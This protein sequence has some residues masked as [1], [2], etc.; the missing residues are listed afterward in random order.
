MLKVRTKNLDPSERVEAT[1]SGLGL[2][3]NNTSTDY[4]LPQIFTSHLRFARTEELGGHA[5]L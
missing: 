4:L 3:M 2:K 1:C 5:L